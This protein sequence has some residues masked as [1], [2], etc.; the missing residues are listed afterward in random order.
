MARNIDAAS[1][2]AQASGE[3]IEA[4]IV[5]LEIEGD[6]LYAWTGLGDYTPSG[7]G[8]DAL[9]EGSPTY[10]GI[11]VLGTISSVKDT[12]QGSQAVTLEMSGVSLAE[13]EAKQIIY[14][15]RKWQFRRGRVWCVNLDQNNQPIGAPWRLKTGRMLN[16]EYLRGNDEGDA[17]ITVDLEGYYAYD[18]EPLYSRW[19]EQKDLDPTDTSQ[20]Y[21]HDL[22]NKDPTT[23]GSSGAGAT[24]PYG[25]GGTADG[26]TGP[27]FH[28]Q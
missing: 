3:V 1:R 16:M 20:D 7:T 13:N 28:R 25:T 10:T 24:N 23:S 4:F 27:D 11:A 17:T 18:Q 2:A 15:G 12:K 9:E 26:I 21:V 19:S 14:E 5:R 6:P 22:A 8:D